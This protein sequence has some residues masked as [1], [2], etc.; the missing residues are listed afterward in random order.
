MIVVELVVALG[1]CECHLGFLETFR[2]A[3]CEVVDRF[4]V[5]ARLVGLEAHPRVSTSIQH[6]WCLLRRGVDRIVP[7][8]LSHREQFVP[9]VLALIG[10]E[11]NIL[12]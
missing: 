10:E 5:Q 1:L 4:R 2:D 6:K 8:E 11:A 12:L 9:I 3:I 7:L